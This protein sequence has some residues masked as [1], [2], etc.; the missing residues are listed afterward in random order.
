MRVINRNLSP[1]LARSHAIKELGLTSVGTSLRTVLSEIN[2][3]TSPERLWPI[4][5]IKIVITRITI[6]ECKHTSGD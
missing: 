5:W 1:Y 3:E 6:A 2:W 4:E